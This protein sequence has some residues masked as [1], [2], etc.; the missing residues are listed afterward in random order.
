MEI[1]ND[2]KIS[3]WKH[4]LKQLYKTRIADPNRLG[5]IKKALEKGKTL[6]QTDAEYLEEKYQQLQLGESL[7][8]EHQ[9]A[10]KTQED[11]DRLFAI[12]KK[13]H[14]RE[15]GDYSRLESIANYL[16]DGQT[17]LEEDGMYLQNQYEQLK[18]VLDTN[19]DIKSKK[20][21]ETKSAKEP[22]TILIDDVE[23]S[24]TE[25]FVSLGKT[26][27]NIIYEST[28]HFTIGIYGEWGT[29]KTTL[30]KAVENN[31]KTPD[32]FEKEQ[33]VLTVW[34]NAWKHEREDNLATISLMKTVA[35]AMQNHEKF[36][37][38][39]KTILNSLAIFGKDLMEQLSISI[40]SDKKSE[41]SQDLEEKLDYLNKLYRDSIYFDGLEKIKHQMN[42]IRRIEGKDCRV[43]IFIDDLDR[44]SPNKAL[45][46]LESIKLF[47]DFEGFVFVIGLSHK[48]VTQLISYAYKTTGVKGD[49][50]IKK[51]IQ[52]PIRIP[53]WSQEG[54]IDLIENKITKDLHKEYT[55]FLSQNS[56][57]VARVVDY[58]P[59]QLKRFINNVI[60]AFETF[61]KNKTP[62]IQFN[63]I[64]LAK[65]LKS[66]WPRFY[67]EFVRDE[68]FREMVQWMITKPGELRKYFKYVKMPTDE[69][70]EEQKDKRILLLD[71]LSNKTN[72]KIGSK[73]ID[74]LSEFDYDTWIFL[75]NVQDVLYRIQDWSLVNQ[76]M[77][78]VEEFSY[79]LPVG[80]NKSKKQNSVKAEN[81]SN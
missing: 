49:D 10:S 46:V 79:D 13:L 78:V 70:P 14:Q 69:L 27:S 19:E 76:V 8:D 29:G 6:Y 53:T 55:D 26:I 3:D 57:M 37:S 50:Y 5:S 51:I 73:Q 52:I 38:L 31:L 71:R 39:S 16:T 32:L 12:I 43:V 18:Q 22:Q 64:F 25:N 72:G 20:I 59:R 2:D 44:C 11:I 68:Y 24:P 81:I 74:I 15:L 7:L 33:K 75:D 23:P 80:S 77:D 9:A 45:E 47:L 1:I 36:S 35:Y 65:I 56:A 34:F 62:E 30:M 21:L 60:I 61:A 67:E 63:D 40:L 58:N 17:L 66:E 48:T 42:E 4:K 54:I 41:D 28:P